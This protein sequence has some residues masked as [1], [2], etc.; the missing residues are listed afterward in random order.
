MTDI[1]TGRCGGVFIEH[2]PASQQATN[3]KECTMMFRRLF[4]VLLAACML[5][6]ACD[7]PSSIGMPDSSEYIPTTTNE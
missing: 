3:Q 1:R 6:A 2:G 5:V 4:P 7:G